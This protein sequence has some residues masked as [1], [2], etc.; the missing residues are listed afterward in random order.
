MAAIKTFSCR[1]CVFY[2]AHRERLDDA[3]GECR[4][5]PQPYPCYPDHWCGELVPIGPAPRR[6]FGDLLARLWHR[7]IYVLDPFPRRF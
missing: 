7:L 4:R 5:V 1:D 6:S 3:Q 2:A